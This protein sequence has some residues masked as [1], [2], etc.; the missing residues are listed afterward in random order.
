MATSGL[1]GMHAR[2][3]MGAVNFVMVIREKVPA[4]QIEP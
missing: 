1:F 2:I 4:S 3:S